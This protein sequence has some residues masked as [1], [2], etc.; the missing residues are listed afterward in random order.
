MRTD[1]LIAIDFDG[2]CVT[3]A[4]PDVG[5]EIGAPRVLHKIVDAGGQLILW[6]MRSGSHL[7][8]AVN[9]F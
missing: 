6:T 3:H 9:W 8:D 4:Y 1:L 5:R 2:T 7:E